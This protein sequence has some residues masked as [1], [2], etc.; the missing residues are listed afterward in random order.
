VRVT[1]AAAMLMAIVSL[2]ARAGDPAAGPLLGRMQTDIP[3]LALG[4]AL[5]M[6]A[7]ARHIQIVYLPEELENRRTNGASGDLSADEALSL[8]L[9][10]TNLDFKFLDKKTAEIEPRSGRGPDDRTAAAQGAARSTG[11]ATASRLPAQGAA[12]TDS[13]QEVLVTAS[14]R[15]ESE[16]DVPMSL[17]V[18]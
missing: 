3:A 7:Q 18:I 12:D 8:L 2:S 5:R 17:A 14:R 11:P 6:F 1:M 9:E 13:L 16:L 15:T 10:G 4:E